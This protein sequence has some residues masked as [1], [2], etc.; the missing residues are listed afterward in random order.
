MALIFIISFVLI[1]YLSFK[2]SYI[3]KLLKQQ[4]ADHEEVK[5]L[6][7]VSLNKSNK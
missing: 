4:Q 3:E 7:K 2:V 5:S 6:L 1:I